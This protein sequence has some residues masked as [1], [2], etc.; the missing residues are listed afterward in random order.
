MYPGAIAAANPDKPAVIMAGSGKVVTYREL[1][2]ESNRLAHLF[3]AAGL[4]PGDHIAF[5]LANHPLFLTIAWA[6]HRSGLYYTPVSSRLQAD[7]LAYIVG[8]CGARV[9]I[10]SA[11]LAGVATSITDTTPEVEL[12]L[13]LD[14]VAEGFASYEAAVAGQPV[15]PIADECLGADMLYS[16]GTTGRPKGVKPASSHGALTEPGMLFKLIEALFAPSSDSVYLSPAP[17]Y[18]AA[19]LRYC[20]TFQRLG[21]TVVVMERF[22]PERYLALVE[23]YGVTHSQLV[24]TMFIKMLKLPPETR[25]KYDISS[26]KYAIHAAA[27]CPVPVKDKMIDWWG[28]IIHEYYAGTEGNGFVYVGSEDWLR[29]K[30]TVGRSLLGIVHICDENGDDLPPGEHGT[31]FFENGGRFEYHGDPGGT[32]S[33]QDPRGRGW[34][35]LGDIGYLDDDGFLHLTDRRSYMIISGGVN[36]YPQEAENVLSVHPKVADVAVIGVPDE[37]MGEQV[38]AVVEP[39]SMEEAGP[40]LE[41]ELIAYCREHLAHYKCPRSVDF[42]EHLPR[43]PTGKLYKRLLRDEYWP[44][45]T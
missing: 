27:P 43:H 29:H 9:F 41:A 39:A 13:M 32:R 24:P 37:E 1:D 36:I 30:G 19:P 4:R 33:A 26:L 11:D 35:T 31:I 12:R 21:A 3:R 44:A 16:S 28:P 5:M 18:H 6:A 40:R 7:E 20:L 34:T 42:R 25:A 15:T 8:N 45:R 2:E 22:D 14:G 23:R 38:K 10:S 17:L